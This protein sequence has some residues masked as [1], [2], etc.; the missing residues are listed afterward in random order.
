MNIELAKAIFA[1]GFRIGHESGSDSAL[2]RECGSYSQEPQSPETAWE[3]KLGWML[4]EDCHESYKLNI[5]D[6]ESWN[7][8]V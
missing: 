3:E 2:A 6:L 5:S 1:A 7:K 4:K 8:A